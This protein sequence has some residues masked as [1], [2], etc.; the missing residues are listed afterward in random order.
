MKHYFIINPFAG[1]V[2]ITNSIRK[3]I[4]SYE[5]WIEFDWETYVT[6]G[7][8]D[9]AVYTSLLCQ[10]HPDEPI[11]IYACGGDGTLNEVVTGAMGH[12]N[13]QVTLYPAGSG[14]DFLR[15]YGTKGDFLD[16]DRLIEG[17]PHAVDVMRI[18]VGRGEDAP[19]RY[20]FNVLGMGFDAAVGRNM[21]RIKRFP[22]I[23]GKHAYNTSVIFSFLFSR[24]NPY[25]VT[26]DG[27]LFADKPVLFCTLNNG[28]YEG[29]GFCGAPFARNDDGLLDIYKIKP[30][31]AFRFYSLVN[32]YRVGEHVDSP[33]CK[34][35]IEFR[36]GTDVVI[37]C[38]K[39]MPLIIDG[40]ILMSDYYHVELL[41]NAFDFVVPKGLEY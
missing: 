36:Q 11:R 24:K 28:R 1:P 14:N 8:G 2:D 6:T 37:E 26:V 23:G 29:G 33:S 13:V 22:I 20:C 16:I 7:P 9:A 19:V 35:I 18:V 40:E 25:R 12:P 10:E 41:H 15:Y 4:E 38:P 17:E 31:S 5:E 21:Q 30:L 39:R 32:I 3:R 34:D 27:E